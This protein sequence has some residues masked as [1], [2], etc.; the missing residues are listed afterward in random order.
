MFFR[1]TQILVQIKQKEKKSF[2]PE[3]QGTQEK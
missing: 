2:V 3:K 1:T